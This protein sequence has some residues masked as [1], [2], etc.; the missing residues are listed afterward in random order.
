MANE[1]LTPELATRILRYHPTEAKRAQ[2]TSTPPYQVCLSFSE[3]VFIMSWSA[4]A[5]GDYDWIGLYDSPEADNNNHLAYQWAQNGPVYNTGIPVQADF[6][7]RYF[8]WDDPSS[9]YKVVA[10]TPGFP[11]TVICSS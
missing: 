10:S 11:N 9:E 1:N 4:T 5:I 6:Q 2:S 8:V 7:A 3:G